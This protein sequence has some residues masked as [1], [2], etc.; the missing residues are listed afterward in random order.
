[1]RIKHLFIPLILLLCLLSVKDSSAQQILYKSPMFLRKIEIGYS[2]YNGFAQQRKADEYYSPIDGSLIKIDN[3]ETRS[4]RTLGGYGFSIG[5]YFRLT[6][7]RTDVVGLAFTYEFN[8]NMMSWEELDSGFSYR[9]TL[10]NHERTDFTV[11]MGL[12]I[13]LDLKLGGEAMPSYNYK[14]SAGFGGGVS[15]LIAFTGP[16]RSPIQ[17]IFRGKADNVTLGYMPYLKFEYGQRVGVMMKLRCF[18]FFGGPT[19]LNPGDAYS[20][21]YGQ[22]GYSLTAKTA[23]NLSLSVYPFSYQWPEHGWWQ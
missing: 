15:P 3:P 9:P 2:F 14:W 22:N 7:F 1:M 6:N 12:P 21:P 4:V 11:Q 16:Y 10:K 17:L 13:G 20:G 19:Y 8:Y 18:L 23:L 5:N